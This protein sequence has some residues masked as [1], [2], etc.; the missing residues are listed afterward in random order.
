MFIRLHVRTKNG[1]WAYNYINLDRI[2]AFEQ[3]VDGDPMVY[4][5]PVGEGCFVTDE[6]LPDVLNK[7]ARAGKLAGGFAQ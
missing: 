3:G 6:P 2:E 7:I 1:T 5:F 4:F